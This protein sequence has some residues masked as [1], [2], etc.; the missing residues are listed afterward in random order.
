MCNWCARQS[1]C[2]GRDALLSLLAHNFVGFL[3]LMSQPH[4]VNWPDGRTV[5]PHLAVALRLPLP[6]L[7]RALGGP[8]F[9]R[10]DHGTVGHSIEPKDTA[11][12]SHRG[13][14]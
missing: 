8:S 9:P 12:S 14:R 4:S 2:L 3:E 1:R 5:E 13:P 10:S 11:T 7:L 6:R